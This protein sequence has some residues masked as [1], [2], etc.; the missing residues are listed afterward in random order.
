MVIKHRI[1]LTLLSLLVFSFNGFAQNIFHVSPDGKG[2]QFSLKTPGNI[3]DINRLIQ[4]N[5][6]YMDQDLVIELSDGIYQLK[7]NLIF[8]SEDSGKN[9]FNVIIK[10]KEGS[11]PVI[12]GGRSIESWQLYDKKKNIYRAKVD[13]DKIIRQLYINGNRAIRARGELDPA[14]FYKT[15]NGY[16][17][18]YEGFYA[19]MADWKNV[20]DIEIVSFNSWKSFRC[21][22]SNI[23][24]TNIIMDSTCW[25]LAHRQQNYQIQLPKWIENAWEL[26]DEPGEWYHDR[27]AGYIFYFPR[28]GENLKNSDIMAG[29]LERLIDV[30]G[31]FD[32]PVKNL[33]FD[34]ITFSHT[35]WLT[36]STSGYPTLQAGY[37]YDEQN[38]LIKT[39][40]SVNFEAA[41]QITI[42]NCIFRNVGNAA[43]NFEK[44]CQNNMIIGNKFEDIS[45]HAIQIGN[46]NEP[47]PEEKALMKDHII[48]NNYITNIGVEYH[49]GIG[50]LVAYTEHTC[51]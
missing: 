8:R 14:G 46:V 47:Y 42:M 49:D 10:A 33:I 19:D 38:K 39:R 31:T 9:G 29:S 45:S 15:D 2:D 18:P 40:S 11:N 37:Y 51:Y 12:S 25:K 6:R 32:Q 16:K 5:N 41:H 22:V 7:Q 27:S 17:M 13:G 44:G 36:P 23:Y 3:E 48:K 21:G 20:E 4:Q 28:P 35:T 30:Q 24:G 34:G 26:L 43:L 50:I 1:I